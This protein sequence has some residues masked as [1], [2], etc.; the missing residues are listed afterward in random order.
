[1]IGGR[2]S[3]GGG[4][5]QNTEVEKALPVTCDLKSLKVEGKS[6]LV[7]IMHA[8]EIAEG[9]MWQKKIAKLAIEKLSPIDM[10]GMLYY[11]WNGDWPRLAYPL[12]GS[13]SQQKHEC[14]PTS[15][16]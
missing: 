1:M 8:S 16:A 13:G 10:M 9:N 6:G 2:Q 14:C 4:G 7:L 5:W 3:F 12:P 11:D 15:T